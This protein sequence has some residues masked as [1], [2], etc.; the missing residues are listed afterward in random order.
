VQEPPS[1]PTATPAPTATP[2]TRNGVAARESG[3]EIKA[4]VL[5]NGDRVY[6]IPGWQGYDR[7]VVNV[8]QGGRWFCNEDDVRAAGF[9]APRQ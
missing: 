1:L 5:P 2:R 3:C 6:Y 8:A 9:R 4:I 7:L